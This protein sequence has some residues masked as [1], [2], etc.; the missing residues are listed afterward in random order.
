M[1]RLA[2]PLL[3]VVFA[4]SCAGNPSAP[5]SDPGGS[6]PAPAGQGEAFACP[7]ALTQLRYSTN[8]NVMAIDRDGFNCIFSQA[9]DGKRLTVHGG[10]LGFRSMDAKVLA[11]LDGL[12]PLAI[13]KTAETS[14]YNN[15][16]PLRI[17]YRVL[18][19]GNVTVKAGVFPAWEIEVRFATAYDTLVDRYW[20][21][22][23]VGFAVKHQVDKGHGNWTQPGVDW[24]LVALERP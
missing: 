10:L 3:V 14:I 19:F 6:L 7:A 13:G 16:G 24:E 8:D 18:T 4:A 21:S 15:A 12:W 22:P 5:S 1:R 2:L 23:A 11:P 9:R 17:T 20:W